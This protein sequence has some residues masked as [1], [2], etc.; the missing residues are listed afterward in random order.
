MLIREVNKQD[1]LKQN[2][3]LPSNYILKKKNSST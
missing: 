2:R 3:V 1:C